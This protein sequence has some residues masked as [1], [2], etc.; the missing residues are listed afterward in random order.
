R[1][2]DAPGIKKL[3]RPAMADDA[4]QQSAGTH[5]AAGKPNTGEQKCGL[6]LRR[7]QTDVAEQGDH[8]AGAHTDAVNRR[9]DRLRA[10]AHRLHKLAGHPR[11]LEE[12]LHVTAG[13]G[14][15]NVVN[16][17]AEPK[18]ALFEPNTTTLI[19]RARSSSRK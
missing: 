6:G 15:N 5:V 10:G 9:D 4:R 1:R 7:A 12:S 17:P 14:P 19:S 2:H 13:K 11:K 18:L 8:R 16:T 3:R